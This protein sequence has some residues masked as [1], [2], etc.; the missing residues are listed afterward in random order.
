Q[1][2]Q[3]LFGVEPEVDG[4]RHVVRGHLGELFG[5]RL[6]VGRLLDEL[7]VDIARRVHVR[8]RRVLDQVVEPFDRRRRV[9]EIVLLLD[10]AKR[11]GLGREDVYARVAQRLADGRDLDRAA[12]RPDLSLAGP[13]D[14]ELAL[15]L[16][17]LAD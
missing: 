3:A 7:T 2:E 16:Q 13:D 5:V 6:V 8:L 10:D 4:R 11:P 1:V 9:G 12:D 14:P 15:G 17:A